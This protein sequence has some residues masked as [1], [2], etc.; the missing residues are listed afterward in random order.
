MNHRM[1]QETECIIRSE[2][3]ENAPYTLCVLSLDLTKKI[4]TSPINN[5][6]SSY[7]F[8]FDTFWRPIF[9]FQLQ[10]SYFR[11]TEQLVSIKYENCGQTNNLDDVVTRKISVTSGNVKQTYWSEPYD[12]L[13]CTFYLSEKIIRI[14]CLKEQI[15]LINLKKIIKRTLC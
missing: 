1:Y 5:Y 7:L 3:L 12:W 4:F 6:M 10:S 2:Y 13:L 9:I 8:T 11:R 15:A 14:I